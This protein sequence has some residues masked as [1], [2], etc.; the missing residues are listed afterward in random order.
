LSCKSLWPALKK[1]TVCIYWLCL[2]FEKKRVR[3]CCALP[4]PDM[5]KP[6]VSK[7][8]QGKT[9]IAYVQVMNFIS[10]KVSTLYI[11]IRAT[12][13]LFRPRILHLRKDPVIFFRLISIGKIIVLFVEKKAMR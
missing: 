7:C 12:Q 6:Y 3:G 2:T 8:G 4:G 1:G 13:L 5:Q 10:V 11:K 9:K